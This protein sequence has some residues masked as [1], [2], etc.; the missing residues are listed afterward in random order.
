VLVLAVVGLGVYVVSLR[1][2]IDD[3][4]DQIAAQQREL[5]E[6]QGAAG[7]CARGYLSSIAGAFDAASVSEGVTQAQSDIEELNSSCSEIFGQ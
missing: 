7:A 1:S 4:D 2:D 5:E 6:Q 3:K